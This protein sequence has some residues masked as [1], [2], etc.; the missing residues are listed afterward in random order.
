MR[1]AAPAFNASGALPSASVLAP[2]TLHMRTMAMRSFWAIQVAS[3]WG[4]P[5]T[6]ALLAL[7]PLVPG[8]LAAAV[9]NLFDWCYG[10]LR[11]TLAVCLI[12]AV[13]SGTL[14]LCWSLDPS[15]IRRAIAYAIAAGLGAAVPLLPFG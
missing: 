14:L 7:T 8:A 11:I 6:F 12:G 1:S 5:A 4:S 13:A 15:S 2:G 10:E 9:L 3:R